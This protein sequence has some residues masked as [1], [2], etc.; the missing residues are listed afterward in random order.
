VFGKGTGVTSIL[1]SSQ[2]F[3]S[4]R[5]FKLFWANKKSLFNKKKTRKSGNSEIFV[6]SNGGN[7]KNSPFRD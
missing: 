4:S 1:W 2:K 5:V 6:A 3:E 7:K